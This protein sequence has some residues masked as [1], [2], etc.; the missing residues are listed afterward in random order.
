MGLETAVL[1]RNDHVWCPGGSGQALGHNPCLYISFIPAAASR[2]EGGG[3]SA[4]V[5]RLQYGPPVH[6]CVISEQDNTCH[7]EEGTCPRTSGVGDWS[8]VL[9]L[10]KGAW[11]PGTRPKELMSFTYPNL[12]PQGWTRGREGR[13]GGGCP[14]APLPGPCQP[15]APHL[16]R[17]RPANLTMPATRGPQR[18]WPV[19][20]C[21]LRPA[22]PLHVARC[23]LR[24][25]LCLVH[26]PGA[27]LSVLVQCCCDNAANPTFLVFKWRTLIG[28]L[29]ALAVLSLAQ[30]P[31]VTLLA[32]GS[33][34]NAPEKHR[35]RA[36]VPSPLV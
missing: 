11:R 35:Q 25:P 28:T 24:G 2:W 18:G 34:K 21:P 19:A 23:P 4:G 1:H 9:T 26:L 33:A 29:R 20:H 32:P 7:I 27:G 17:C 6:V 3:F 13:V 8:H 16:A 15:V 22:V 31:I 14:A 5:W 12:R 10:E 36:S 30:P